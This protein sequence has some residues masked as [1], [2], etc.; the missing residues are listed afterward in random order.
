MPI[1]SPPFGQAATR[2]APTTVE[3][4]DGFPCGD[5]DQAL[6]NELFYRLQAEM[7]SVLDA[8]AVS[9]DAASY[10]N[11]LAAINQLIA[12]KIPDAADTSGFVTLDQFKARLPIYPEVQTADGKLAFTKPGDGTV[13]L[14]GGQPFLHRGVDPLTTDQTDFTTAASKTYHI[15]WRKATG[16]GLFDLADA[17]YTGGAA[18][19]ATALDSTHDDMLAA[20]VVTT[21][22]NVA[23]V[24]PLVNKDRLWWSNAVAGT[25]PRDT[26]RNFAR[27]DFVFAWDWARAPKTAL[28]V[29]TAIGNNGGDDADRNIYRLGDYGGEVLSQPPVDRYGAKFVWVEDFA[30]GLTLSAMAGA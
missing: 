19:A 28:F 16:W 24:T 18:E 22:S 7:K 3:Q 11:L 4:S 10:A 23:T 5:A 26:G 29:P 2:R 8:A 12:N 6:F 27:F 13:R 1:F 14:T 17:A 25:N 21:A 30:N 9:G 20:K 15:R